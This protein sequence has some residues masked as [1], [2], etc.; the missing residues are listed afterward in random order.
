[1][2]KKLIDNLIKIL[3]KKAKLALYVALVSRSRSERIISLHDARNY[4]FL[5]KSIYNNNKKKARIIINN[6]WGTKGKRNSAWIGRPSKQ[7]INW[8]EGR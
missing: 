2:N 5:A 8:A 1:M 3:H 4:H 6:L 7:I